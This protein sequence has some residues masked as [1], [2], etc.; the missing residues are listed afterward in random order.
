[1]ESGRCVHGRSRYFCGEWRGY[2][3]G[4]GGVAPRGGVS[5]QVLRSARVSASVFGSC[6]GCGERFWERRAASQKLL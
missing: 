4:E 6:C 2:M 3:R 5:V 1:M